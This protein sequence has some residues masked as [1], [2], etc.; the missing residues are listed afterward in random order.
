MMLLMLNLLLTSLLSLQVLTV[1]IPPNTAFQLSFDHDN[2]NM[3]SYRLWCDDA[4]IKN[5]P[6]SEILAGKGPIN[7][8]GTYT[9]TVS[10]PGLITGKHSCIISAYNDI[11]ESKS[12]PISFPVGVVPSVPFNL[13][14]VVSIPK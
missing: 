9:F 2:L 8:D 3:A 6:I 10:A 12:T 13:R 14:I 5:Y 1:S 11:G 4:I 7:P